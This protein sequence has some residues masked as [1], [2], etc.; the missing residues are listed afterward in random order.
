VSEILP[1]VEIEPASGPAAGT[2]LWLHG[3]GANGHDFEGIVPLLG[4]RDVRFVFPHA[5]Q[6]PVTINM[7][8]IM[9]AWYDI[10]GL[11]D[12]SEE[13]APGVAASS[14]LI[15]NLIAREAER[16]VSAERVVLAGFSQGGAL[17]LSVGMRHPEALRGIMVLSGYELGAA[18]REAEV[19]AANQTT[20]LLCCHGSFD[21]M[22]RLEWGHAAF[23][24]YAHS[25]RPA[26]WREF[27][28]A[29]EV[30][31]DEIHVIRD[32]LAERFPT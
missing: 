11:D 12:R 25:G 3:L 18:R 1:A 4:R 7:G 19:S 28:M 14:R 10:R 15:E 6:R 13:D 22:V 8:L 17:A 23:E 5:P 21:P 16:G 24:A 2:V 30:S 27:P 32:W 26:L 9:P 29:H 31:M 20:P